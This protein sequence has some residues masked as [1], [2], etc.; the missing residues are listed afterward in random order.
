[1]LAVGERA[2]GTS[3]HSRERHAARVSKTREG[4]SQSVVV[5]SSPTCKLDGG[6]EGGAFAVLAA[7]RVHMC[8]SLLLVCS[9]VCACVSVS[10]CELVAGWSS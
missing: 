2:G 6:E 4:H 9:C 1:V 5:S 7:V 10:V 8:L 3:R